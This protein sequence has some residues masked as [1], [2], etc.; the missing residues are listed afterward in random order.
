LTVPLPVPLPTQVPFTEKQ[1]VVRLMPLAKLEV[2]E[3]RT[4]R[5]PVVVALPYMVRPPPGVPLPMVEEAET[6]MPVVEVGARAPETM[7]HAALL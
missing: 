1:P 2:P 3:P 4:L 5:M 6:M 7:R